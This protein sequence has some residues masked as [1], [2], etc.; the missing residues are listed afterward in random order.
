MYVCMYEY[1]Y[2]FIMEYTKILGII[3]LQFLRN[4]AKCLKVNKLHIMIRLNT[5]IKNT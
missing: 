2:L 1:I 4:S 5:R 3:M